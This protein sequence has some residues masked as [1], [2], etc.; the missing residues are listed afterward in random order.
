MTNLIEPDTAGEH[1]FPVT[2]NLSYMYQLYCSYILLFKNTDACA[3]FMSA[4]I[5]QQGLQM[6]VRSHYRPVA[7]WYE[8]CG[9][10]IESVYDD[11][12]FNDPPFSK[13]ELDIGF[14]ELAK[15]VNDSNETLLVP[16]APAGLISKETRKDLPMFLVKATYLSSNEG[17]ALG[18]KYHHSLFDG[19]SFWPFMNNWAYVCKTLVDRQG[20]P[21]SSD[22]VD[23]PFPPVFG[24]PDL[25]GTQQEE[26]A[27]IPKQFT[28]PEYELVTPENCFKEFQACGDTMK[29]IRMRIEV[30]EQH[31]IRASAKIAGVSF[32]SML[33]ALL[34]KEVNRLRLVAKPG[35]G[36]ERSL[37]TCTVNPRAALGLPANLCASPVLNSAVTRSV[38]EIAQFETNDL[39]VLV[40]QTIDQCNSSDYLRSS[41]RF[42]LAHRAHELD[43]ERNGR[44]PDKKVM[45]V[46]ICP[47]AVKCTVSS[48]RTFPIYHTDFGFGSPA[49]VRPPYLPFDGCWRIWPTPESAAGI[50]PGSA[51]VKEAAIEIYLTQ[52][53]YI[54]PAESPLLSRFLV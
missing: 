32:I 31:E 52:P 20:A 7:G 49:Y 25:E 48:S 38:A 21:S 2:N 30:A 44:I 11:H 26:D 45:L 41:I 51:V 8:V 5:L 14:D 35:V 4:G 40:N 47:A 34:W 17:M 13:Q 54:D 18:V 6:L 53:E 29:E 42:L 37:Y 33:S 10:K 39:A 43:D 50:A 23:I 15:H 22:T 1:R 46:Y 3:D 16:D 36:S 28:H 24:F 27:H 12:T 9:E 19:A